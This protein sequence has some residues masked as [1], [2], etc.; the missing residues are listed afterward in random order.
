MS[1]LESRLGLPRGA[2]N[3]SLTGFEFFTRQA[4]RVIKEAKKAGN[5]RESN[6]KLI[7]YMDG[8]SEFKKGVIVIVY[9]GKIQTM[10]PGT[11]KSFNKI[12]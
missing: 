5:V 4:E 7:Y 1:S 8:E 6:G 11:I 12:K 3:N 2:F 9:D 10:M